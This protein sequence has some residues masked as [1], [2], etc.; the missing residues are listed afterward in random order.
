[1]VQV[2][3]SALTAPAWHSVWQHML[4]MLQ[5]QKRK[6]HRLELEEH[7]PYTDEQ[8][9]GVSIRVST[10][11]VTFIRYMSVQLDEAC[12]WTSLSLQVRRTRLGAAVRQDAEEKEAAPTG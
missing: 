11:H 10:S 9:E 5:G 1:M 8:Q 4:A 12:I 7:S 2:T 6:A 3:F